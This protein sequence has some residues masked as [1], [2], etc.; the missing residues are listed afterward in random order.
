MSEG[1]RIR[2]NSRSRGPALTLM[3]STSMPLIEYTEVTP[4]KVSLTGLKI[5]NINQETQSLNTIQ[6][7][8]SVKRKM[9]LQ[10]RFLAF[11]I[12]MIVNQLK[13]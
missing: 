4:S 13:A 6:V 9:A 1:R 5:P 3:K 10:R 11:K 8:E 2:P 12:A 7:Q